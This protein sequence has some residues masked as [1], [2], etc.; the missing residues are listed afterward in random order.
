MSG[1]PARE[2]WLARAA[3]RALGGAR[4]L[5]R[6]E[7][8]TGGSKKGVYRLTMDDET[9]AVAYLWQEAENYWPRAE[10]D[11]DCADPFSPGLG[12]SVFQAAH[13]R[14][15]SVGARVP[16][17]YL[18]D[19]ERREFP[20]DLAIVEDLPGESLERLLERDPKAAAPAV[21]RLAQMLAAMREHRAAGYGKVSVVDA[22]GVS[23]GTSCEGVVFDRA[24]R[25]LEE[26]AG[27]DRRIADARDRLADRLLALRERVRPRAEMRSCTASWVRITCAST[28]RASRC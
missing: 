16:R 5:A 25:D 13:R 2:A 20:A 22:G 17:L 27:R 26:A 3:G 10:G 14:L 7:R 19:R 18:A 12:F 24:L 8:L 21:A 11:E 4:R 6:I 1:S 28:S 15:A 23:L 9:T